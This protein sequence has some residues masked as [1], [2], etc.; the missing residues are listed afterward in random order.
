MPGPRGPALMARDWRTRATIGSRASTTLTPEHTHS[1][2][3]PATF[4]PHAPARRYANGFVF[5]SESVLYI[6]N[7]FL[8]ASYGYLLRMTNVGGIWTMS[9]GFPKQS[10]TF[11]TPDAGLAVSAQGLKN[12]IGAT[13]AATGEFVLYSATYTTTTGGNFVVRYSTLSDTWTAL[14]QAPAFTQY[15]G[16]SWAPRNLSPR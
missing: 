14:A 5:E 7:Y 15:A 2:H 16:V 13:D 12:L 9:S 11:T 3:S 10:V 1:I 6:A 4:R 8:T